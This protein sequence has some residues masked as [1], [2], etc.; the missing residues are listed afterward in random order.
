MSTGLSIFSRQEVDEQTLHDYG[1]G[2]RAA[3]EL[4][5]G[6]R[7][8]GKSLLKLLEAIMG[9]AGGRNSQEICAESA[10]FLARKMRG[11]GG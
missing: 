10:I 5:V 2:Q 7:A 9:S 1:V 6:G 4:L 11:L 8:G 3:E